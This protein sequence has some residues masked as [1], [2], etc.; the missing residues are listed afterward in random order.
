MTDAEADQ[1]VRVMDEAWQPSLTELQKKIWRET[2]LPQDAGVAFTVIMG[3]TKTEKFRPALIDYR[4]DY[5]RALRNQTPVFTPPVARE[6]MP[7][8]VRGWEIARR[9]GDF[10]FWPEQ[11]PGYDELGYIWNVND[12]MPQ[13]DRVKYMR[14]A[15]VE[16]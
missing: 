13:E 2:A 1:F 11:K 8:W 12:V 16:V 3:L 5:R 7:S 10:R 9:Q 4:A 15:G 14:E 6:D